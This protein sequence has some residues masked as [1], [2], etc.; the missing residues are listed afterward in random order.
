MIVLRKLTN[1]RFT[2][3]LFIA[4]V[5]ISATSIIITS[6]NGIRMSNQGLYSLG[7]DAIKDTHNAVVNSLQMYNN[8]VRKK[9]SGDLQLLQQ[10]LASRGG[11][12]LDEGNMIEQSMTNQSTKAQETKNIPQLQLGVS[13]I[14]G[15]YDIVDNIEKISGSSATI[16]QLV[17]DKLLRI[18]TTVKRLDGERATGTYIP[19]DSPVYKTII[20]GEIFNGRAFVVNEWQLTSYAPLR[21]VDDNIVGAIFVG[22]TMLN[23]EL[24]EFISI[25]KIGPGYFFLYKPDGQ[26]LLHPTMEGNLF[27]TAPQFK[28]HSKGFLDY[29]LNGVSKAAY[30]AFLDEFDTFLAVG[31]ERKD[32]IDGLDHKMILNNFLVGLIVICVG[33]LVAILLVRSINKP[34][35]DLA[36]K[37]T[38]VGNG[39]YTITFSSENQ[40][41]IGQLTNALGQMTT[42]AK[43]MLEDIALSSESLTGASDQLADISSNMLKNADSTTAISDEAANNAAEVSDNMNSVSAAMEQSTVNLDMIAAASEEM[44]NTI[45]EIAE[46]SARARV[47]TENAV[48]SAQ[49]S[50]VGVMELGEAARSIG[51]VT[52]A[53][54]EISEQTNLLALNATI[55]AAR[56]GD[57]GKGFAVVANE[58]KDLARETASATGK[59]KSAVEDIQNQ[60]GETVKDIESIASV[61]SEVNDIVNTIVTAVEEQSI[62]TAEIVNNVNQAST[63]IGEINE[64]IASSSQMTVQLSE[65][66]DQVKTTSGEV[67]QNSLEVSDSAMGLKELSTKLT[68]LVSKFKI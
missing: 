28:N 12:F 30:V 14:N 41:A 54:T 65:G 42:R 15:Y 19:S 50:H 55:E 24:K 3:K 32:L 16:F 36:D 7:E 38:L 45:Q 22:Q 13:Y 43:E 52:E 18:S 29:T 57:A 60:T 1:I 64:N 68:L 39:D 44:G 37:S 5:L 47:T 27:E 9:L 49:K 53:I 61:I 51:T 62:T 46:N 56:A 31:L 23:E 20:N 6:A 58:I 2:T 8:N 25:T 26:L 4:V 10:E 48:A 34:L 67:K 63:G 21:D 59:I 35:R 40:D 66:V 33:I 17:G 11:L